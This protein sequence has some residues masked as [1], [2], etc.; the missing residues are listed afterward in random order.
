MVITLFLCLSLRILTLFQ[1][2]LSMNL[3]VHFKSEKYFS[4]PMT[5]KPERWLRGHE[6]SSIHPFLLTPFGHGARTCAGM[7]NVASFLFSKIKLPC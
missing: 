1:S 5:F 7:A 4:D 6:S 3:L 2:N